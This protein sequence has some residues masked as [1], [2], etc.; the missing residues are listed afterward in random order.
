MATRCTCPNGV[1]S[2]VSSAGLSQLSQKKK[3]TNG[4]RV[5]SAGLT[6]GHGPVYAV[7]NG[8]PQQP[9]EIERR[10]LICPSG[11][12][13]GTNAEIQGRSGDYNT[14]DSE[15]PSRMAIW[16]RMWRLEGPFS[17]KVRPKFPDKTQKRSPEIDTA[18]V[19][20]L[21]FSE[22]VLGNHTSLPQSQHRSSAVQGTLIIVRCTL[23]CQQRFA[24]WCLADAAGGPNSFQ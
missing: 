19:I 5:S 3:Q 22:L 7:P 21:G 4:S 6:T 1:G 20:F 24:L 17:Q 10:E 9:S 12:C 14:V 18:S 2:R 23:Y 13:R 11:N 8:V 16:S 15:W